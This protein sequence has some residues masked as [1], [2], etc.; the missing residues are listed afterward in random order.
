MPIVGTTNPERMRSALA[1]VSYPMSN[2]QWYSI[3]ESSQ[4]M[5][6]P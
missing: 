1:A 5:L 2:P 6:M 4:G 3:Y